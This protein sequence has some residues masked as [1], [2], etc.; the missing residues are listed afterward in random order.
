MEKDIQVQKSQSLKQDQPKEDHTKIT[1]IKMAKVK[2]NEKILKPAREKQLITR[3]GTSMRL[4]AD[5][6]IKSFI[7][8]QK[9]KEFSIT[10]PALQ[11]ILKGLL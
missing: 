7:N 8:K 6:E 5:G 9:L 3:Y 1:I 4:S 10:K 2:D 11:E